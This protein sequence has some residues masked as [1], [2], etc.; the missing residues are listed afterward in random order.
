MSL[1][2]SAMSMILVT[3]KADEL[4]ELLDPWE[5]LHEC[6]TADYVF[7]R[8]YM[9]PTEAQEY[10]QTKWGTNLATVLTSGDNTCL[11]LA[12]EEIADTYDECSPVSNCGCIIG[13]RRPVVTSD[14][15]L[16]SSWC[17]WDGDEDCLTYTSFE[18]WD[19]SSWP[20]PQPN[21]WGPSY[22]YTGQGTQQCVLCMV[23]T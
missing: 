10:C 5:E 19:Q 23:T 17:W 20:G 15:S 21:N 7:V 2:I 3:I 12:C 13:L 16:P 18:E 4:P 14:H 9:D 22:P 6:P 8:Y 11:S 1:L